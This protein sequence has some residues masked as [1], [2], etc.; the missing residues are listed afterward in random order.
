MPLTP[1][2]HEVGDF[3]DTLTFDITARPGDRLSLATM[4]ICTNDGFTG[5]DAAR[6]PR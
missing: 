5:L 4:L 1:N 3:T 6:L 2:G